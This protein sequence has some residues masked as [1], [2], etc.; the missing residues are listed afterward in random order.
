MNNMEFQIAQLSPSTVAAVTAYSATTRTVITRVIVC[1]ARA[2]ATTF[3]VYH[4]DDGTT[5]ATA[6]AL[7]KSKAIAANTTET[8]EAAAPGSGIGMR[9]GGRIGVESGTVDALTFSLYGIIQQG[10]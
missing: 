8:I 7:Y 3:S 1:N 10:R 4:D 6:T 5:F 9:S 2:S